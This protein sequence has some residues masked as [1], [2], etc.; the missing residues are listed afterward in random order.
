M[1]KLPLY[2]GLL[3]VTASLACEPAVNAVGPDVDAQFARSANAPVHHVSGGG[4][5]DYTGTEA[6]GAAKETYGFTASVN[7]NGEVKGQ[8]ESHW[9]PEFMF[10]MDITCLVVV[11]NKAWLGGV[12]TRSNNDNYPVG[13]QW[14]FSVVDNGEGANAAP[15]QLSYF[16]GVPADRCSRQYDITLFD[17]TSGNVQVK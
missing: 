2:T 10:H 7:G 14:V 5:V 6:E 13:Q 11:D 1:R 16:Y 12:T 4:Q 15:D 17:W 3:F 9:G 8:F